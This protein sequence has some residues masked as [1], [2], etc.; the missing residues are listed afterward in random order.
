[1][2]LSIRQY[3]AER[4]VSHTAV[5][6]R[7]KHG[8]IRLVDGKIDPALADAEWEQNRD[9]RQ[10]Q[11]GAHSTGRQRLEPTKPAPSVA[12]REEAPAREM[13]SPVRAAHE[14]VRRAKAAGSLPAYQTA[15]EATKLAREYQAMRREERELLPRAEVVAL[16]G[17]MVITAKT[18]LRGIGS[19][20]APDLAAETEAAKCQ[21]MV[22]A[23][24]DA[25]LTE[26][27]RWKPA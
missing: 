7:I 18:N 6:K 9:A 11:R 23:E 25:A 1:M 4:G 15:R 19:K 22:D 3:A 12:P 27:S 5:Q 20:L 21:A 24:I 10:Q 14:E 26:I 16:L 17:E 8:K 13:P 2:L